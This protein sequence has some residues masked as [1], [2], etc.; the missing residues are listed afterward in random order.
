MGQ[1]LHSS[2]TTKEATVSVQRRQKLP[3]GSTS[4]AEKMQVPPPAVLVPALPESRSNQASTLLTPSDS[5]N[6]R[7]LLALGLA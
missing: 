5:R 1:V 2:V 7:W 3:C 6:H 4:L